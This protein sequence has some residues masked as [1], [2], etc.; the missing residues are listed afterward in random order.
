MP[1]SMP[2]I[3]DNDIARNH[4]PSRSA[5]MASWSSPAASTITPSAGRP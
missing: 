3:T 1:A 2:S 5:P 4:R